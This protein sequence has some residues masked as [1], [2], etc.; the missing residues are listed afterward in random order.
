M[1]EGLRML[2]WP[3]NALA[4]GV[5]IMMVWGYRITL[6]WL[7]GGQCRHVPTC[8]QYM[9]DAVAKH[10]PWRG[11]WMGFKRVLRCHPWGTSGYDPA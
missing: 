7:L 3:V 9:L 1:A 2:A 11:G 6:G 10:G 4:R 5:L 8:S